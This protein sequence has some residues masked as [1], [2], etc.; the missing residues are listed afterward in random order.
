[1]S[2]LLALL[3]PVGAGAVALAMQHLEHHLDRPV[4][5]A[6]DPHRPARARDPFRRLER[7]RG[8]LACRGLAGRLID[9]APLPGEAG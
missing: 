9:P 8:P 2:L 6:E 5:G 7:R 3:T 4:A 1:M